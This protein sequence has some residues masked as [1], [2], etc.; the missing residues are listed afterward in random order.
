MFLEV[1][2]VGGDLVQIGLLKAFREVLVRGRQPSLATAEEE[3]LAADNE[4]FPFAPKLCVIDF[5]V[6]WIED[7]THEFLAG[8][9]EPPDDVEAA[10]V[11]SWDARRFFDRLVDAVFHVAVV[12][13]AADDPPIAEVVVLVDCDDAAC[14][15]GLIIDRLP[16]SADVFSGREKRDE[17]EKDDEKSFHGNL[18]SLS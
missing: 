10:I 4:V 12:V 1:R 7:F 6:L 5:S 11:A 13:E 17:G 8:I 2:D 18:L 14:L 16:K 9:A 3:E 15:T